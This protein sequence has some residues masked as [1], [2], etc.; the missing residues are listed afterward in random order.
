MLLN[1]FPRLLAV[2]AFATALATT[3]CE[4][5][6]NLNPS[7]DPLAF[8]LEADDATTVDAVVFE[9][10]EDR[11]AANDMSFGRGDEL[12]FAGDCF[13]LVYPVTIALPDATEVTVDSAGG[14]RAAL[15]TWLAA[16][17]DRDRPTR[18]PRLV[19]PIEVQLR[20][21]N[22]ETIATPE[23]LRLLIRGCRP[24]AEPCFALVYPL[25]Y[26]FG[27]SSITFASADEVRIAFRRYRHRVGNRPLRD[28]E[29][30]RLVF[31]VQAE[32]ANGEIVTLDSFEA[33]RRLRASCGG[34]RGNGGRPNGNP[35]CYSFVF[36]ISGVNPAG[37]TV[38]VTN[39][40]GL[41]RM[42]SHANGRGRF[43]IVFPINV[44][45]AD[46]TVREIASAEAFRLFRAS[47]G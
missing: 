35:N 6:T 2:L 8:I 46:G 38:T 5:E 47:C 25:T 43:E 17:P 41:R 32:T 18:R 36:P 10:D 12:R 37:T 1:R 19:F 39:E 16:N 7:S 33:M 42:L 23:G 3:A 40:A 34:D 28:H 9:S 27:D 26:I 4:S 20:D 22:L 45:L 29:R 44:T 31:P 21:G 24:E 13:Q 14:I 11:L 15:R 30:P